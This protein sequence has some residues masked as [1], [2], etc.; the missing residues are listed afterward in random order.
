MG[1]NQL[2]YRT[3]TEKELG[4]G[5]S[6]QVTKQTRSERLI[7]RTRT[8]KELGVKMAAQ[9]D[10]TNPIRETQ[11]KKDRPKKGRKIL[12]RGG[13]RLKCNTLYV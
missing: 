5:M 7:Y 11:P 2:H 13:F 9:S 6:D 3:R 8:E 12:L 4:V 10:N 1:A